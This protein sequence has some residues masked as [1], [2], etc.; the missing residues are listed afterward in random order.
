MRVFD[1]V[2]IYY[3]FH[4]RLHIIDLSKYSILVLFLRMIKET[5]YNS[6]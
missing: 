6:L 4:Y 2:V 3:K 1:V 5:N